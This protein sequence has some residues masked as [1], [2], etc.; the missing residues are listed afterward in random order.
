M[1]S[2]ESQA[3]GGGW[4][5]GSGISP[6]LKAT[7]EAEGNG[8][9]GASRKPASDH[10]GCQEPGLPSSAPARALARVIWP[11]LGLCGGSLDVNS[12]LLAPVGRGGG[13]TGGRCDNGEELSQQSQPLGPGGGHGTQ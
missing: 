13:A 8:V 1:I 6:R 12:F 11:G 2:A 3:V 10:A 5:L 4:L 7:H 9:R